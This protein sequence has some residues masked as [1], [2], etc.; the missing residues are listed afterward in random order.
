MYLSDFPA[1]SYV[2]WYP[3]RSPYSAATLKWHFSLGSGMGTFL[4]VQNHYGH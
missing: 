4:L 1:C 2:H 3:G